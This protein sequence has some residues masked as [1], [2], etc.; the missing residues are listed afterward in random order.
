MG[1]ESFLA[2]FLFRAEANFLSYIVPEIQNELRKRMSQIATIS[3]RS[4]FNSQSESVAR[5]LVCN[6]YSRRLAVIEIFDFMSKAGCSMQRKFVTKLRY[7]QDKAV[8]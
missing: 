8:R 4:E 5:P 6:G 7:I 3:A 2:S 1:R